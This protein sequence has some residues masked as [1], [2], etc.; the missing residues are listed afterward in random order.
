M[1]E[2]ALDIT[3]GPMELYV[4][5]TDGNQGA[6][7]QSYVK[8]RN[9]N[10]KK[11]EHITAL[12]L[13]EGLGLGFG[14]KA[15][16]QVLSS[17]KQLLNVLKAYSEVAVHHKQDP[18]AEFEMDSVL[19]DEMDVLYP[20]ELPEPMSEKESTHWTDKQLGSMIAQVE[21]MPTYRDDSAEVWAAE[22]A[23]QELLLKQAKEKETEHQEVQIFVSSCKAHAQRMKEARSEC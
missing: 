1:E 20:I 5:E 6:R 17:L 13:L 8:L 11:M 7:L 14:K 15:I 19:V 3:D 23:R 18:T 10:Q 9:I 12:A 21:S 16:P 2:D 22:K 4:G